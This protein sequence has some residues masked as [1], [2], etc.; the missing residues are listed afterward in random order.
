[1][2]GR[3]MDRVAERGGTRYLLA[4]TPLPVL[5]EKCTLCH[6]HYAETK[7]GA[8]IGALSYTIPME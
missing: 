7:E 8:P 4:A 6:P 1:M 5:L 2:S 3:Q